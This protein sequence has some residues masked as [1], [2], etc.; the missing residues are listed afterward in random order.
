MKLSSLLRY[1][2]PFEG[3]LWGSS[4]LTIVLSF[5]CS[6]EFYP[7]T[8]VASLVGVTALLFLAKGNVVGQFLTV[9]FSILYALV[10]LRFRYWGELITYVGMTLPAAVFACISWLKN[11]SKKGKSEVAVATLGAKQWLVCVAFSLLATLVFFFILRYF[12]TPNLALSTLSITTSF[13]ACALTFLRSRFYALAYAANDVVLIF[14][15]VLAAIE[16]PSYLPMI[17]CFVAFLFND[18]Y[19]FINW[20]RI[21]KSQQDNG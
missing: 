10:S 4:V 3:C 19:G 7:L 8:L 11:P 12:N 6:G 9:A 1:F 17:F 2:S 16:S 13:L 15:W 14:L 20:K 18:V 5:V 21:Q